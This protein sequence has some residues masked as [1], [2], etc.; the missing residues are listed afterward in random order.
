MHLL[1]F[2]QPARIILDLAGISESAFLPPFLLFL[3]IL[4]EYR[5]MF[6]KLIYII[7]IKQ[8]L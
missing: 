7:L 8:V 1:S 4:A 6:Y 2:A 3:L 5:Y